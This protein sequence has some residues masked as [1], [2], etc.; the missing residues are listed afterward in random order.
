MAQ[1]QSNPKRQFFWQ[2]VAILLPVAVM[3]AFGF[4]AIL[5][6][7][8]SVEQNA[9]ER[10]QEILQSLPEDF[11]RIAAN[12]LTYFDMAK[13]GWLS[14]LGWGIAGWPD[15]KTSRQY[16]DDTN[17]VASIARE[18]AELKAAFPDWHGGSPPI[19]DLMLDTNGQ[20]LWVRPMPPRP[21]DWLAAL[22]PRQYQA[23]TALNAADYGSQS[24]SNL[25]ELA[26]AFEDTQ[27]SA[28][29]RVC[30]EFIRLRAESRLQPATNA[31][32]QL[33]RFAGR[34]GNVESESG[35]P[36]TTLALAESLKRARECGPTRPL[37]LTMHDEAV[38]PG[39]LTPYLLD[40]GAALVAGNARLSN[41]IAAMRILVADK[42]AQQE[43]AGVVGETGKLDG[44]ITN[45]LWAEAMGR[46]WFC[47]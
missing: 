1:T 31:I 21:P 27:P 10:A 19:V 38:Q 24:L 47:I 12:R 17:E 20:A 40:E 9:R 39:P 29:A 35:L 23:W 6:E 26:N 22:S 8:G 44:I 36:L 46:R 14:Y 5:R 3:A 34:H 15:D 2:G 4:W 41:G 16:L 37:W 33:I 42:Q 30:A 18:L 45:N 11:G 43:L 28:P 25:V 7:R 13:N 32:D